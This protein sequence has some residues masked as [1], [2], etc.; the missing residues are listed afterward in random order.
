MEYH[1]LHTEVFFALNIEI[2][3]SDAYALA[4]Y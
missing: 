3:A 1:I 4:A 2:T